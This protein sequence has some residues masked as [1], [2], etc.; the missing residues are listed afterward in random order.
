MMVELVQAQAI[1]TLVE[2]FQPGAEGVILVGEGGGA[3]AAEHAHDAP[4]VLAARVA[5]AGVEHDVLDG[6]RAADSRA[7]PVAGPEVAVHYDGDDAVPVA[8][9]VMVVAEQCGHYGV[10]DTLY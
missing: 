2:R 10:G 6:P 5:R 1:V 3:E 4:L 7:A 8:L 9:M